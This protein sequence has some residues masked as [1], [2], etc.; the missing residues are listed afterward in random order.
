MENVINQTAKEDR[1]RFIKK[2]L[3]FY[4]NE[5]K[6]CEW[7]LEELVGKESYNQDL[8]PK[9]E[10]FQ[11]Q[12]MVQKDNINELKHQVRHYQTWIRPTKGKDSIE[13]QDLDRR[14]HDFKNNFHDL[15]TEFDTFIKAWF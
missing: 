1:S 4:E 5:I 15:I 6:S 8:F 2:E 9:I 14:F 10:H 11:N 7:S 3:D 12:F 13:F